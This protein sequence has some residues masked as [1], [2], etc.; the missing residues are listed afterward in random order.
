MTLRSQNFLC[1]HL[2][3]CPG[4]VTTKSA[5]FPGSRLPF[6]FSSNEAPGRP[7]GH[8]FQRL[9]PVKGVFRLKPACRENLPGP[10]WPR[11]HR[12][13][14]GDRYASTGKSVPSGSQPFSCN[15]SVKRIG[16]PQALQAPSGLLAQYM[17][18]V[19]CVGCTEGTILFSPNQ[20]KVRWN[21]LPVHVLSASVCRSS[22]SA[23]ARRSSGSRCWRNRQWHACTSGYPFA[24]AGSLLGEV[25]GVFQQKPFHPGRSV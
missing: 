18:D 24:P 12:R 11:R 5:T 9:F 20:W 22:L 4:S 7:D 21:P 10:S 2:H 16:V 13:Y 1:R 8:P 25:S 19:A 6:L 14:A 23:P 3:Q 17:S 15:R